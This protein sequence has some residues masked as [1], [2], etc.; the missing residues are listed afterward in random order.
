MNEKLKWL[1]GGAGCLVLIALVALV[2]GSYYVAKFNQFV[3]LDQAVQSSWAQVEVQL[4]RRADL[5]PNLVA[6]VKGSA[7]LDQQVYTAI[8]ES[9]AKLG[10]AGTVPERVA[11]AKGFESALSRLL[12]VMENYPKLESQQGFRQLQDELAGT[13][14]RVNVARKYY[15]DAVQEYNTA[16]Q[17]IPGS[18]IASLAGRKPAGFFE[19]GPEAKA[20]PKVQF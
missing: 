19:A 10:G 13:E 20:G 18:L 5:V 1:L 11:A 2:L 14:N 7:K 15:N 4:Q 9:R 8:A 17:Q 3:T 6:T 16:I 12:V